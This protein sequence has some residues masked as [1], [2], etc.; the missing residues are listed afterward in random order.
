LEAALVADRRKKHK[1][2]EKGSL[3]KN[4]TELMLVPKLHKAPKTKKQAW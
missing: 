1:H 2:K 4:K 3:C